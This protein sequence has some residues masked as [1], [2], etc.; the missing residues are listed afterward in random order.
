MTLH[1]TLACTLLLSMHLVGRAAADDDAQ[2]GN[3]AAIAQEHQV[4]ADM[5]RQVDQANARA[6]ADERQATRRNSDRRKLCGSD[7]AKPQVGMTLVRWQEC[8]GDVVQTGQVNRR[9]GVASVYRSGPVEL[10]VMGGKV[11]AWQHR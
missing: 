1:H 6:V 7:Y 5:R 2:A 11:V 4:Q 3:R 9:D 8:V 10:A